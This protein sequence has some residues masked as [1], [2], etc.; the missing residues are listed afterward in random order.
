ML[1]IAFWVLVY[2]LPAIWLLPQTS[3]SLGHLRA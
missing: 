1:T 3:S 2:F